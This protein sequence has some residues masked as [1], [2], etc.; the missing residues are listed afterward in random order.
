LQ[1]SSY[2][3]HDSSTSERE[4]GSCGIENIDSSMQA[5]NLDE[6]DIIEKKSEDVSIG[7]ESPSTLKNIVEGIK[8]DQTFLFSQTPTDEL[9]NIV[10]E[11]KINDGES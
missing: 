7:T 9:I 8:E 10:D 2:K 4:N 5:A 6:P 11:N 1:H 3:T